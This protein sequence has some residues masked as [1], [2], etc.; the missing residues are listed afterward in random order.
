MEEIRNKEREWEEKVV[1]KS[2]QQLPER[3]SRFVT[4]SNKP[5][6]RLYTPLDVEGID[7][8][9][10]I[11]YPGEYPFTRGVHPTMYRSKMFTMRQFA[12]FGTPADTNKRYKYLLEHGETGLSVAFSLHTLMGR[13]S[14]HPTSK[15]EVGKCGVA[16]DSL[17]DME[18]LFDG[19]PL[20]KVTTSMTMNS[21]AII[22]LAMYIAT[23]KKQGVTSDKIGGTVQNDIFKEFI[24]QKEYIFPPRPSLKLIVDSAEY[25][26]VWDKVPRWNTISISGYHIREAG[27]TA[28][29]ELAFTLADGMAYV[30]AG[31]ERGLPADKFAN[32]LSFFFNCHNDFFEEIAKFRAARKIWAKFMRYDAGASDPRSWLMRFHTQ[33]AGCS[34]SAQQPQLNIVR[35]TIQ[36]LAAVLGG[37]QSLHTNSYDEAMALPSKEAVT[38]ALRTQQI[39]AHESGVVNVVDP[40]GGSYYV[41]AL[42]KQM[43]DE[44]NQYFE[45]IKDIG[46]GNIV[47]G[48]INGIENGFFQKEIAD[49]AYEY[50]KRIDS[51]DQI[52][53]GVNEYVTEEMEIPL[54]YISEEVEKEQ[55]ERTK[56]VREEREERKWRESLD[57]LRDAAEKDKNVMPSLLKAVMAYATVG[58]IMDVFREIYG[59]YKEPVII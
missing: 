29:Q 12:G 14:D 55:V 13:D 44:A 46:E 35:T 5:V 24:S 30:M 48:V 9:E 8:L 47:E 6:N 41:E 4:T 21:P 38:I 2:L 10:D 20:D 19:I 32:R 50:Q 42:T 1:K 11:G 36:A 17:K 37:T 49:S 33:N 16:V 18:I 57:S 31:I 3:K 40:L 51:K 59:E 58:E 15:G 43:E 45:R 54:L 28:V 7:F 22:L 39:I 56:K 26:T 25:C 52:I 53:V 23:A 27:A 34:L